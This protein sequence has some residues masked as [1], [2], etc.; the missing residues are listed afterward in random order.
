MYWLF[1]ADWIKNSKRI[2]SAKHNPIYFH[3][4][5]NPSRKIKIQWLFVNWLLGGLSLHFPHVIT[6]MLSYGTIRSRVLNVYGLLSVSKFIS[7]I[8]FK[9]YVFPRE[10][11]ESQGNKTPLSGSMR[12][13]VL[14]SI[15]WLRIHYIL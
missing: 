9:N 12:D 10:L 4:T 8:F 3:I 15:S 13:H 2:L 5:F 7:Q 11:R 1:R 6:C 14:L